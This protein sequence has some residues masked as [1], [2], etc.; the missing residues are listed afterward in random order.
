M[1][2]KTIGI[3]IGLSVAFFCISDTKAN[4]YER[5]IRFSG[6]DWDVRHNDVLQGPGPNYFSDSQS[7]VWVDSSGKLHMK[8][9]YRDGSWYGAEVINREVLGYGKYTFYLDAKLDEL[10]PNVVFGLFTYDT[11]SPDAQKKGYREID[12]EFA[13]W[14]D[15]HYPNTQYTIWSSE[16]KRQFHA[17]NSSMPQGTYSTHSFNWQPKKVEFESLGGHYAQAPNQNFIWQRWN[18][19]SKLVPDEGKAK[20]HMNLWLFNGDAPTNNS[21]VEVIISKFTFDPYKSRN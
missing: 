5:Q 6:Y 20:I 11:E 12:I 10:D 7:N 13:K 21:E 2:L 3:L 14:A 17:F 9:T 18:Y 8:L 4:A 19:Q 1:K 15:E 16:T